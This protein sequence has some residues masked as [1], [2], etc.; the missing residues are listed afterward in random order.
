MTASEYAAG[1]EA[2]VER[3][4]V[5]FAAIDAEWT[6]QPPTPERAAEYW[7]ERLAIRRDAL[8]AVGEL[9]P[10]K[11]IESMHTVALDV[12][13]RITAAD[14]A[15]ADRA[16]TIDVFAEHWQWVDTPEGRTADAVLTEIYDFCR[17][18]QKEFDATAQPSPFGDLVWVPDVEVVRV[19][20]GCP[21][22]A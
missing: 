21:P 18:S 5:D 1:A 20:F 13:T 12:F 14:E 3:M 16:A 15:L 17:A 2:L 11:T 10:P 7:E 9:R 4:E 22:S 19:A 8:E 6:S